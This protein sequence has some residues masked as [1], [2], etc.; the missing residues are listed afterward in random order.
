MS[1][2]NTF[3]TSVNLFHLPKSLVRTKYWPALSTV[4]GLEAKF[5]PGLGLVDPRSIGRCT[6]ATIATES[7]CLP[8][9]ECQP[10]SSIAVPCNR[11][12]CSL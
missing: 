8:F 9:P 12:S 10:P 6:R 1:S 2:V 11:A 4:V 3:D 7:A 5:Q